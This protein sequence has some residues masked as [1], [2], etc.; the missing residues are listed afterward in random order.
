MSLVVFLI[1]LNQ[2]LVIFLV[3]KEYYFV[4]SI[5]RETVRPVT[6]MFELRESSSIFNQKNKEILVESY[7]QQ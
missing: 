6:K 5:E 7:P 2:I 3:P 4:G 1:T